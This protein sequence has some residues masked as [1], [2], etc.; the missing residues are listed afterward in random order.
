MLIILWGTRMLPER[1]QTSLVVSTVTPREDLEGHEVQLAEG[2]P[3]RLRWVAHVYI[4]AC[5]PSSP[6]LCLWVIRRLIHYLAKLLILYT[7]SSS[8]PKHQDGNN[9]VDFRFG[10]TLSCPSAL[11]CLG[12]DIR[13]LEIH[14]G[15]EITSK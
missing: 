11:G 6:S 3:R 8:S 15:E 2:E 7:T 14:P 10:F 9:F 12:R 13:C 5:L 1:H 4:G